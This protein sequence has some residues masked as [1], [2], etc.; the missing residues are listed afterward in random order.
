MTVPHCQWAAGAIT[1]NARDG[2][3]TADNAT[4]ATRLAVD[5]R[6]RRARCAPG[7]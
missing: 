2:Q 6:G 3:A 1:A 4:T 7:R 5:R